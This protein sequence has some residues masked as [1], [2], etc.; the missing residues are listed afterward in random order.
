M[1]LITSVRFSFRILR[2]LIIKIEN[3]KKNNN[4][5]IISG[6]E[7]ARLLIDEISRNKKY[8]DSKIVCIIDDNK[9][10]V[11]TYLRGIQI[12]GTR[13]KI[14]QASETYQVNQI[15]KII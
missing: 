5:M 8:F 6:G 3:K 4:I 7:A 13:K 11:G 9:E 15:S 1:L 12:V 14:K 10:K 2:T